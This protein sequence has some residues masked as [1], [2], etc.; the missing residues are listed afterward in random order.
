MKVY[1]QNF[2]LDIIE[3]VSGMFKNCLTHTDTYITLY[4]DE[5]MYQ[6][7]DK[8]IYLLD[9]VDKDSITYANFYNEFTL[10]V[11][12]SF[13]SKQ[14]VTS[15]LGKEHIS[16]QTKQETYKIDASSTV[17]LVILYHLCDETVKPCD[18][19]FDTNNHDVNDILIKKEIIELLSTLN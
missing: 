18:I 9:T 17:T 4:T 5:G 6:I 7:E 10:I 13:F 11:D 19:Y 8:Q 16:F 1:I 15:V 3:E 14:K 2:N 12:P